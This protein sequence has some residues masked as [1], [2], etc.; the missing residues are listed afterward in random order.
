MPDTYTAAQIATAAREL[1]EAAGSEQPDKIWP[2]EGTLLSDTYTLPEA[3]AHLE[4]EIRL[5]RERGFT[6]E[7]IADLLSGFD[8]EVTSDE[9]TRYSPPLD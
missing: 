6:D 4:D 2:P 8:I 9:L 7:H 5:L 1:L 3:L